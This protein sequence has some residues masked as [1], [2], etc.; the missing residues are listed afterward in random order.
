MD[1]INRAG[2]SKPTPVQKHALPIGAF[3]PDF[4]RHAILSCDCTNHH[5]HASVAR[6]YA[7]KGIP[8]PR[9]EVGGKVLARH[10]S[11]NLVVM[12]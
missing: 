9:T 12:L 6:T 3:S 8:L 1:N 2:Y 7:P 10:L 11:K 5:P 4:V